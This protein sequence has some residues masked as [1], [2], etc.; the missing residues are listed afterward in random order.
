MLIEAFT[1]RMHGHG[2]HDAQKYVPKDE[3]NEWAERDPLLR[4]RSWAA[5]ELEWSSADQEAL[6]MRVKGEV[7]AALADAVAAPFPDASDLLP[8][9]FA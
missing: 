6:E 2:A 1:Y 7:D 8:S 4:W 3:L 5:E 9:V